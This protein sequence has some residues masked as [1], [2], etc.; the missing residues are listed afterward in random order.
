VRSKIAPLPDDVLVYPAHGPGSACGK[1]I[2]KETWS[3]IGQQKR[4]N[5]ALQ[6][7]SR[8]EFVA[9]LTT[10]LTAPPRYYFKDVA[11]NKHG[12][13]P[14]RDVLLRNIRSM[15][16]DELDLAVE[17]GAMVLDVRPPEDFEVGHVPNA[18]NIGLD[19]TYAWWAGTLIDIATPLVIIAPQ[20]REEEAVTRLARIGYENVRGYLGD[21]FETWLKAGRPIS[22][23][24]SIE[25][26][27]VPARRAEGLAVLDVRNVGE[28]ENGHVE[29]AIHIPLGVLE[30]RLSEL[31]ATKEYLVHCAAGYRSMIASSI[32]ERHGFTHVKNVHG[33]FS[34]MKHYCDAFIAVPGA[35]AV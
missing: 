35:V 3:T 24:N 29:G 17:S 30:S 34:Q 33:G 4:S 5:Y 12:A 28:Y 2:G 25:S 32:L 8:E 31:D 11:I 1:N 6:P 20:G 15:S 19:G 23:T 7:M 27:E 22:I 9:A 26:S 21:G 13:S 18:M 14:L 16:L 10:G